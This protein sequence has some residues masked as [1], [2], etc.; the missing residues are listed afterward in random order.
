MALARNSD[1]DATS[2]FAHHPDVACTL[3][4]VFSR[5]MSVIRE[6]KADNILKRADV[7]KIARCLTIAGGEPRFD[8]QIKVP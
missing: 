4:F 5:A 3:R 8:S 2:L 1:L 6:C 7:L